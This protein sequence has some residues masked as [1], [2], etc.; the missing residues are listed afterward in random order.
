MKY[1]KTRA[2]AVQMYGNYLVTEVTDTLKQVAKEADDSGYC[3][4]Y[5]TVMEAAED[6]LSP[7]DYKKLV[8]YLNEN[9]R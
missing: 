2:Q 1:A 3:E 5:N 4:G 7:E 8:D 9:G 6:V